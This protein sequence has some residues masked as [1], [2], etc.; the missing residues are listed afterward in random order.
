MDLEYLVSKGV[1]FFGLAASILALLI[2]FF[3]PKKDNRQVWI[4]R[5]SALFFGVLALYLVLQGWRKYEANQDFAE[6]VTNK[7]KLILETVCKEGE[8][9]YEQ[10]YSLTSAGFS[11]EISNWAI[12]DLMQNK[13]LLH[14]RRPL[15]TLPTKPT[16]HAFEVRLFYAD[17]VA[18]ASFPSE[19][20]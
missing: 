20:N 16:E 7:E 5:A 15:V 8:L 18:C 3:P 10:L 2:P 1:E 11:D 14:N 13:H 12:D 6:R 9:N 4:K 19:K 17:P